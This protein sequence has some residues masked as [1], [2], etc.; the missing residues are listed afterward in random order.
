MYKACVL[1][2]YNYS[3]SLFIN[4]RLS[5]AVFF[6]LKIMSKTGICTQLYEPLTRVLVHIKF[7]LNE[8]VYRCLSTMSTRLTMKTTRLKFNEFIII[9]EVGTA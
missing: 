1:P 9:K 8:P 2:G 4:S 3:K 6:S 7:S 5:P